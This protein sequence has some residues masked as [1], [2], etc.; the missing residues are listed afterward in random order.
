MLTPKLEPNTT[1]PATT[2][3]APKK[4]KRQDEKYKEL[5]HYNAEMMQYMHRLEFALLEKSRKLSRIK[6]LFK[7]YIARLADSLD[8]AGFNVPSLPNGLFEEKN[9]QNV[10]EL[11]RQAEEEIKKSEAEEAVTKRR[12]A[13]RKKQEKAEKG[14]KADKGE[15]NEKAEKIEKAEKDEKAEKES[16]EIS[17]TS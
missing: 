17:E 16:K 8:K 15:K 10:E 12:K 11:L 2:E 14:E 4:R 1:I 9:Y 7:R 6:Y 13:G 3:E 5:K